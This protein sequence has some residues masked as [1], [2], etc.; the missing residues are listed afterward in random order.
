MP[1][2]ETKLT[3]A[4]LKFG[5]RYG[6]DYIHRLRRAVAAHLRRPHRF[7]CLTDDPSGVDASVETRPIPDF[8]LPRENW[9]GKGNWPKIGFFEPGL[10]D[11]DELVFYIDVDVMVLGPLDKFVD[12]AIGIGGFHHLQEWNPALLKLAPKGLRPN[13]GG[14]GSVLIWRAG[15][16]RHVWDAFRADPFGIQQRNRGDRGWWHGAVRDPHF[17][18]YDWCASFKRH[19]VW[20]WPLNLV[21]RRPTMP[22]GASLLVFHGKPDPVELVT[23]TPDQRWGAKRKFGYGPVPWVQEYWRRH[24]EAGVEVEER[25]T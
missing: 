5:T 13:R 24:G 7:L 20:Y 16:Q 19:C 1:P 6:P 3:V 2:T 25:A 17:L 11:D 8:G 22:E 12:R 21:F 9:F 4:C 15:E 14:Q 10:F 23:A 18:P